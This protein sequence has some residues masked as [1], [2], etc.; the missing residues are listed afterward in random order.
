VRSAASEVAAHLASG[1]RVALATDAAAFDY[2]AGPAHRRRLL[3][4]LALVTP[5]A[6]ARAKESAA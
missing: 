6:P 4:H 5:D 2:G 3:S 1:M